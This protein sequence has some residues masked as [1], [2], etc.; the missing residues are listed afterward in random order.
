MKYK[1]YKIYTEEEKGVYINGSKQNLSSVLHAH[2]KTSENDKEGIKKGKKSKL[3][4]AM[5]EKG[6][7]KFKIELI[8]NVDVETREEL[9]LKVNENIRKNNSIKEG[10]NK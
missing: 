6:K 5:R 8:E 2:K 7:D 9:M 4:E 10:Y 1:I 3:Y